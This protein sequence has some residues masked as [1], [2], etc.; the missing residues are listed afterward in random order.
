VVDLVLREEMEILNSPARFISD[1]IPSVQTETVKISVD[2]DVPVTT[3]LKIL[4]GLTFNIVARFKNDFSSF[5]SRT[6]PLYAL[7]IQY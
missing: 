5:A 2:L 1:V 7:Q 6:C 3:R 4:W